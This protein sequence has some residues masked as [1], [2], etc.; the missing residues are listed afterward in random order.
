[1]AS[2]RTLALS[3]LHLGRGHSCLRTPEQLAPLVAGFQ[4]VLLLGDIVD[5]W[6]LDPAG[7]AEYAA[8]VEA[9]CRAGGAEQVVWFRGNHD[10]NSTRGAEYVLLGG[11]LYLHGHALYHPLPGRGEPAQRMADLNARKFGPRRFGSRRDKPHWA[12]IESAYA[13]IP[14]RLCAPVVWNPVVCLRARKLAGEMAGGE[15][16]RA[17]VFGHTHVPGHRRAGELDLVNLGGWLANTRACGF[18]REGSR[19]QLL[20]IRDRRG[21]PRWS[22][23]LYEGRLE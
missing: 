8:R 5:E 11:V 20:R 10:A 15:R 3:D 23:T 19:A 9:V 14:Q 12:W 22:E 18:V 13:H 17:V 2:L 16:V 21:S 7:A 4:R 1:M 6:Y